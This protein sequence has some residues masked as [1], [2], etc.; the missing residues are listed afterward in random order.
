MK[1]LPSLILSFIL[2]GLWS[3]SDSGN[4]VS[5]VTEES[6]TE[7]V[8]CTLDLDCNGVCGGTSVQDTC[9]VCDGDGSTCSNISYST[10][11]QPIFITDQLC[12]SCHSVSFFTHVNLM[13]VVE[14]SDSTNSVLIKRLKGDGVTQMPKNKTPLEAQ[15]IT[16]IAT[17]IQEGALDN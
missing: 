17:W 5:S 13:S 4:P 10:T 12:T 3:C 2:F 7:E 11:I 6:V 9:G 1:V 8:E 14:V 15:I 16:T